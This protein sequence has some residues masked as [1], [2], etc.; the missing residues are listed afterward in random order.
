MKTSLALLIAAT[1]GLASLPDPA[2]A[3]TWRYVT[4]PAGWTLGNSSGKLFCSKTSSAQT[5]NP[6]CTRYNM[7][8]DW[9]W[10]TSQRKC[11]RRTKRTTVYAT[12]NIKCSSGFGY[13]SS[14]G[15]CEKA[16]GKAYAYPVVS[17]V[18]PA[19]AVSR[20]CSS[21][22]ACRKSISC[23]SSSYKLNK[24]GTKYSCTKSLAAL[25]SAPTCKRL[26]N[27]NDWTWDTA[28]KKC[29]RVRKRG[30]QVYSTTNISCPTGY[31]YAASSGKCHKPGQ[32]MSAPPVLR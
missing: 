32:I 26:N 8:N 10:S 3:S 25:S 31:T 14:S 18:Q 19:R 21:S 16:G 9:K 22:T 15:K 1:V 27:H 7:A 24:S 2:H 23:S 5:V 13:K 12:S 4:C 28:A 29:R 20:V 11:Y 17:S 6:V 30:A